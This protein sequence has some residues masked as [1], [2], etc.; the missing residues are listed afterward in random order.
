MRAHGLEVGEEEEGDQGRAQRVYLY[1]LLPGFD[2]KLRNLSQPFHS[3]A[4]LPAF[5]TFLVGRLMGS[6][7]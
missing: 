6:R 2:V 5:R 3:G 4:F 7:V 1:I